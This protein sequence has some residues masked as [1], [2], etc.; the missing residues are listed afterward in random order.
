LTPKL[1][2][3]YVA[4]TEKRYLLD[5]PEELEVAI[6]GRYPDIGIVKVGKERRRATVETFSAAPLE[7]A[8]V[9]AEK[10][11]HFWV[12]IRDA[13][14]LKLVTVIEFLSPSNKRGPGREE[15]LEKRTRLLRSSA[16]LMEIDLVRRGLRPPMR[17]A[18]PKVPYFIFLSRV[19]RRPITEIW[20]LRL[21]RPLP[22]VPVPLLPGDDDVP[23]DLQH[24]FTSVYDGCRYDLILDY[25]EPPDIALPG[26]TMAW[27]K[28]ILRSP[29]KT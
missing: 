9:L 4:L 21:E 13:K 1:A 17:R 27:L 7:I 11:P 23:L 2:P 5:S 12:E 29:R 15:Y 19:P 28:K 10:V 18:L 8:T 3:H 6:E 26:Q 20:P 14:N 16:H 22:T 25:H 24:A